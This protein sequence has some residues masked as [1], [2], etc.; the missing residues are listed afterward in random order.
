MVE[1]VRTS[2]RPVLGVVGGGQLARMMYQAAISLDVEL[3]I[4]AAGPTDAAALVA[5]GTTVGDWHDADV[6][7]RFAAPCEVITFDHELVDP[8]TVALVERAGVVVRPGADALRHAAD[9]AR[10]RAL[11]DTLGIATPDHVIAT[12]AAE[13]AAGAAR[14]GYPVVAKLARGGYDGRGV[15]WLTDDAATIALFD[16]LP[17]G[18]VVV[19]EPT[20]D[21]RAELATQVVRRADG[22]MVCYPV[23]ETHQEDGICRTIEAP[24]SLDPAL[25]LQAQDWATRLADAVD[26]VGVLAVELFVTDEG[27]FVNELA[28]RPH[29]SGHYTID[30]CVTSQF[31][32]H[33]RAVL[34]L[35]LGAPDLQVPAAVMV[36]L[37][38]GRTRGADLAALT[39]DPA[40]R[41]HRYGKRDAPGRKIGHV[42]ICGP[43]AVALRARADELSQPAPDGP[44]APPDRSIRPAVLEARS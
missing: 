20:L 26:V 21:L 37:I 3:R 34:D 36:N 9:K 2:E 29:N 13:A 22:A 44:D 19:V 42:T 4:L 40:A 10:Q 17:A 43:D 32:N 8:A 35:P 18:T 7:Q 11:C 6:L 15:F 12:T 33:V 1:R 14:L 24:A 5:P 41:V 30:A 23:V 31:E 38:A 16:R 27:L 25:V 28:P 39:A